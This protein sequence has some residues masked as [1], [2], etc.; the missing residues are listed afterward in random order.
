MSIK[1]KVYDN[2][3]HTCL[4]WLPTDVKPIRNCRGFAIRRLRAGK[5]EYL[6]GAVGFSDADKLDPKNPWKFPVQ[7]YLW[8]D[9]FVKPGDKVQYSVVARHRLQG[10]S[11]PSIRRTQARSRRK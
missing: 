7:R 4:V 6:H 10:T 2:G 3:D 9:Y 1:L 5:E 11:C 8:W